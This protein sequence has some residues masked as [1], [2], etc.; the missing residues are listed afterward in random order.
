MK[1]I[2]RWLIML[3]ALWTLLGP[4]PVAVA[5]T[6]APQPPA[7]TYH[8]Q[9]TARTIDQQA[10]PGVPFSLVPIHAAGT[11]AVA[12]A[13][14]R[15]YTVLGPAQRQVADAA[16]L[17]QWQL[18][19]GDY[20]VT[21]EQSPQYQATL[22]PFLISLPAMAQGSQLTITAKPIRTVPAEPTTPPVSP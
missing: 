2:W 9:L 5:G 20:V 18:P 8:V 14:A 16:G 12:A 6:S 7:P 15:T 11:Q 22:K 1:T 10:A 19:A 4:L 13:D 21:Q 17:V 3:G